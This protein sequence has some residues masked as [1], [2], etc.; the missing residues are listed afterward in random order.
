M[1]QRDITLSPIMPVATGAKY[2]NAW[3]DGSINMT[4]LLY[5]Q[6]DI[7]CNEA[8][9]EILNQ[10]ITTQSGQAS[11][12][13]ALRV[14]LFDYEKVID[15]DIVSPDMAE[16]LFDGVKWPAGD[17]N[18]MP[19]YRRVNDEFG[20]SLQDVQP[21]IINILFLAGRPGDDA[22]FL[23][24]LYH[25][26]SNHKYIICVFGPSYLG[27]ANMAIPYHVLAEQ[28]SKSIQVINGNHLTAQET[29]DAI[30]SLVG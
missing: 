19:V 3:V 17:P 23:E 27:V 6:E 26:P 13:D 18:I 1:E 7:Y 21:D 9:G 15:F 16:T 28:N 5:P 29:M 2:V 14:L 11:H 30:I 24:T 20:S 22:E 10:I 8:V 12:L 4:E 25:I